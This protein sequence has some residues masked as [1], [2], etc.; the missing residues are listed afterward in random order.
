MYQENKGKAVA[1]STHQRS[2]NIIPG[3]SDV[4]VQKNDN[5][6]NKIIQTT[7]HPLKQKL[8]EMKYATYFSALADVTQAVTGKITNM[9]TVVDRESLLEEIKQAEELG[10]FSHNLI[11][12]A[13]IY[14]VLSQHP[15]EKEQE[16]KEDVSYYYLSRAAWFFAL[17]KKEVELTSILNRMYVSNSMLML[18]EADDFASLMKN[19]LYGTRLYEILAKHGVKCML[20]QS[21]FAAI[22]EQSGIN[23]NHLAVISKLISSGLIVSDAGIS[24]FNIGKFSFNNCHFDIK[25]DSS[26][27]NDELEVA[28]LNGE[29]TST[30]YHIDN[31]HFQGDIGQLLYNASKLALI[32]QNVRLANVYIC[33]YVRLKTKHAISVASG[34]FE[35]DSSIPSLIQFH[36]SNEPYFRDHIQKNDALLR[37]LIKSHLFRSYIHIVEGRIPA[38]DI[39]ELDALVRYNINKAAQSDSYIAHA[40]RSIEHMID[41][42]PSYVIERTEKEEGV[43]NVSLYRAMIYKTMAERRLGELRQSECYRWAGYYYSFTSRRTDCIYSISQFVN[44]TTNAEDSDQPRQDALN[45][46]LQQ[47]SPFYCAEI[48]NQ[49]VKKNRYQGNEERIHFLTQAY[50]LYSAAGASDSASYINQSLVNIRNSRHAQKHCQFFQQG[51]SQLAS[52]DSSSLGAPPPY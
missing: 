15:T 40:S 22:F 1:P 16:Q 3:S 51:A 12:Y 34:H 50:H 31:I 33:Q 21:K 7:N 45:D 19:P 14:S 49:L 43:S 23:V 48:L 32:D 44:V 38:F 17:A 39:E 2:L 46:Q 20:V 25:L 6:E 26:R 10:Q 37:F 4:L 30:N 18:K 29:D 52:T 27:S 47:S 35:M 24:K 11:Y 13:E 41:L 8:I 28:I 9:V 5:H 36:I 42:Y